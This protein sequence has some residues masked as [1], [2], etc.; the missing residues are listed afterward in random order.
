[1]TSTAKIVAD[2]RRSEATDVAV[3]LLHGQPGTAGDWQW[4]EPLIDPRFTVLAPDRPG[5]GRTGGSATGFAGNARS[6]VDLLDGEGIG[7]AIVVAHSWAG[8]AALSLAAA[9]PERTRG[10]VLVSSVGPSEDLSWDDRLLAL[11]FIGELIAAS[12]IGGLGYLV[13]WSRVQRLALRRLRGRNRDAVHAM[14]RL[15]RESNA[16]WRSFVTEQRAL[17]KELQTLND[18]IA[19][20]SAPTIVIHGARD[21]L[22]SPAV[23]RA[24]AEAITGATLT[25]I[26]RAGHLL[27]H[28]HPEAIAEAV[29]GLAG[30]PPPPPAPR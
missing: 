26:D 4:V 13:G 23:A 16:V 22:V 21:R 5:Y 1:M 2:I 3:V 28:D 7:T 10:L 12:T 29:A 24:T 11:P 15:T 19:S 8:G 17:L 18:Q 6:V 30:E 20:I 9:Y 14:A 25:I 27:P